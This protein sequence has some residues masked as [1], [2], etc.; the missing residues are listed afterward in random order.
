MTK[1]SL[2]TP[3]PSKGL[4][5]RISL[6]LTAIALVSG[7]LLA[8]TTVLS[9]EATKTA[10]PEQEIKESLK[11]RLEK[12]I[13]DKDTVIRLKRAWVGTLD[14]IAN[15]T[16][17]I[18]TRDGPK[19]ASTS[20]ETTFIRLPKRT[21]IQAQDLEI[22]SYTIIMG[23]LNGNQVLHAQR[24]IIDE[25]P[26][27]T[28]KRQAHFATSLKFNT[29]DDFLTFDLATGETQTLQVSKD[30]QVTAG[31]DSEIEEASIDALAVARRAIIITKTDEEDNGETSTLLR[32]HLLPTTPSPETTGQGI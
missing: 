3:G 19:L 7:G 5:K 29:E 25:K 12:A 17:T 9:Q 32:I 4:V 18:E 1:S 24:V 26:K 23:Y 14:S 22:G 28:P 6:V 21:K 11:E 10:I 2:H 30:T 15:H 13:K 20:A 16:L 27:D 8:T 31:R